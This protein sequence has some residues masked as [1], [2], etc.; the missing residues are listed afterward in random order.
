MDSDAA[1]NVSFAVG[2]RNLKQTVERLVTWGP[3]SPIQLPGY[4][5]PLEHIFH[6]WLL[7]TIPQ[8]QKTWHE[9]DFGLP[10]STPSDLYRLYIIP[11]IYM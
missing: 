5:D 9:L 3:K 10:K 6:N 1:F 8:G 11:T 7:H 2:P 4:E